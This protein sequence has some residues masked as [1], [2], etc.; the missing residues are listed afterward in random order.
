MS[1]INFIDLAIEQG[2]EAENLK[3][4]KINGFFEYALANSQINEALQ[5]VI[6]EYAEVMPKKAKEDAIRYLQSLQE[7]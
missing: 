1:K 5:Q 3:T 4:V 2:F 6:K 7:D